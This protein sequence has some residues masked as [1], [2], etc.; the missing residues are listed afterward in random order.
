MLVVYTQ[1]P[2]NPKPPCTSA[3]TSGKLGLIFPYL[4]SVIVGMGTFDGLIGHRNDPH[5]SR[6]VSCLLDWFDRYADVLDVA[7]VC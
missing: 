4:R 3:A 5:N 1:R 2:S 7:D 6:K